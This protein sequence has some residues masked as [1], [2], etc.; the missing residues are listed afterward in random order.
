MLSA[1]CLHWRFIAAGSTAYFESVQ[2][3]GWEELVRYRST[4]LHKLVGH[5]SSDT[6]SGRPAERGYRRCLDDRGPRRHRHRNKKRAGEVVL[7]TGGLTELEAAARAVNLEPW[8]PPPGT[9]RRQCPHCRYYFAA[10]ADAV[11]PRCPDCGSSASR[12]A[13]ADPT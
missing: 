1:G 8:E 13:S 12:S 3:G 5:G 9:V 7:K 2:G 6:F 11:E 10:P 4:L